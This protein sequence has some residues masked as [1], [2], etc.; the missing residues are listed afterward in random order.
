LIA[1]I[2]RVGVRKPLS[3]EILE[4][5]REKNALESLTVAFALEVG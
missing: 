3:G 1:L 4:K 5:E 2:G